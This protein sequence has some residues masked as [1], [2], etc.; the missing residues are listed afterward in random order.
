VEVRAFVDES[1]RLDGTGRSGAYLFAAV[2]VAAD[3]EDELR[4]RLKH[5]LPGRLT[6]FHWRKDRDEIRQRALEVM[7]TSDI[8]GLTVYRL[9]VSVS[10]AERAR[11]HAL[12]NLVQYLRE[13]D[14]HDLVFEA[15]ERR[16]NAK[17]ERTLH[18]ISRT[19]VSSDRF[20][21]SFSRP[22]DEPLL[23]LPDYLAG[24]C[25]EALRS[26]GSDRYVASL[27]DELVEQRELPPLP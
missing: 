9:G 21:Y 3:R 2:T 26:G 22:L 25:G 24:A 15:R 10:A 12:W 11:Q 23:W 5:A 16:Q 6:R 17:D 7:R 13:T 1:F 14:V 18:S 8:L 20:R 19:T 27:P 4:V